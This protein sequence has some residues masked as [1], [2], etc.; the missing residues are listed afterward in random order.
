M[1]FESGGEKCATSVSP[2]TVFCPC[3]GFK[4]APVRE[5]RRV[6]LIKICA[7]AASSAYA[8]TAVLKADPGP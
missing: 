8:R 1:K 7:V 6:Q 4:L 3:P 2:K 5:C